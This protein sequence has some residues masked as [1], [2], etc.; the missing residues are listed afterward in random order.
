[1][2]Q[3]HRILIAD[4]NAT[5]RKNL[6]D[7]V[8]RWGFASAE[9][10]DGA[11]TQAMID[12]YRPH[13][14]LLDIKM[15]APDGLAVLDGIQRRG[16]VVTTF[17]ISGEGGI[18][19]AVEAMKRGAVDYLEK[20][21]EPSQLKLRLDSVCQRN[22]SRPG[23]CVNEA[24]QGE[25]TLI[26]GSPAIA[27]ILETIR[28]VGP[29]SASVIIQGES[30]TGKELAARMIHR[31]STRAAAPYVAI[32]CA[33]IPDTLIESELFG[34][35]RGAFTGA[36]EGRKGCFELAHG[37]TLMLD[38]ITEMKPQLQAKLLRVLEERTLRRLGGQSEIAVDVRIIAA[39]NRDID[40]AVSSGKLRPDLYY[41]LGVFSLIMPPLR[42][43]LE[44]IPALVDN[45]IACFSK[46]NNC[47]VGGADEDFLKTLQSYSW[48]GNVRQLRNLIERAM[49]VTCKSR[50]SC[51]DLPPEFRHTPPSGPSFEVRI[52][53]S[54]ERIERELITRTLVAFGG[55]KSRA[56]SVLGISL[57]TLY[58]RL[59]EL[60]AKSS[61]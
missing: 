29:T 30:G 32:N 7:L 40:L 20:P 44:D 59:A 22:T 33:A 6:S 24:G 25:R 35:E 17:V 47:K 11:Q 54:L 27:S 10:R 13:V 51:D 5:V 46:D 12:A 3:P 52:G 39:S 61:H 37:G 36:E 18:G 28:K 23:R 58:N 2:K 26:G 43:R 53:A 9:A 15:P 1:M 55:N 49:T 34:H 19:D 8:T 50:L 41:R 42:E 31:T 16:L 21:F 56:A 45:F 4:D 48:P 57:R 14:L 38:E 60:T